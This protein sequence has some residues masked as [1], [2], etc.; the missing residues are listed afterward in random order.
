MVHAKTLTVDG[1]W[2]GV[3]SA[4]F[5]NRSMSLNDEVVLLVHDESVAE[6]LERRFLED[7]RDA[8]ELDLETFLARGPIERGKEIFYVFF[9]RFL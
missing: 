2:S 5:D 4:N 1:I 7:L 6:T 9:S 3:G 8:T